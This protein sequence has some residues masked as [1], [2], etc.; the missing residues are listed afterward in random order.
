MFPVCQMGPRKVHAKM[1]LAYIGVVH[2]ALISFNSILSPIS[3]KLQH[4]PSPS[5]PVLQAASMDP[6]QRLLLEFHGRM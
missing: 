5:H 6:Q 3:V 2:G 4:P 1:L